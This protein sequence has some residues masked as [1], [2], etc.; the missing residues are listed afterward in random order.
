MV[1][2]HQHVGTTMFISEQVVGALGAREVCVC[3]CLCPGNESNTSKAS[4]NEY[5]TLKSTLNGASIRSIVT[6][7]LP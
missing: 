6:I 3:N 7:Q 4:R 2:V 1:Y 5:M